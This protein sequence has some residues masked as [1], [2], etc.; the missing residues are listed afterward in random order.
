MKL[1]S[2]KISISCATFISS[3]SLTI[4]ISPHCKMIL[5]QLNV[6]GYLFV[7]MRLVAMA[8][9]GEFWMVEVKD[10]VHI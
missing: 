6:G 4:G 1:Q 10:C 7:H 8:T 2:F 9:E 3:C 5:I